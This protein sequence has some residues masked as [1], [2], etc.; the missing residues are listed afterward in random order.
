MLPRGVCLA[1]K[2]VYVTVIH[3]GI[4]T[5]TPT[6]R[7]CNC[8]PRVKISGRSC[9]SCIVCSCRFAWV[10]WHYLSPRVGLTRVQGDVVLLPVASQN[11]PSVEGPCARVSSIHPA[12]DGVIRPNDRLSLASPCSVTCDVPYNC[13]ARRDNGHGWYNVLQLLIANNLATF[14]RGAFSLAKLNA[15]L[16]RTCGNC[17]AAAW[18]TC[19]ST[20]G[21]RAGRTIRWL[22]PT[23]CQELVALS[24]RRAH[25]AAV[26]SPVRSQGARER[27]RALGGEW[28]RG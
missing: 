12:T 11:S 28:V 18:L 3:C 20:R 15:G 27:A 6:C 2:D 1:C 8:T 13:C 21:G 16:V 17:L 4:T 10:A 22:Q 9:K 14:Y 25:T 26:G 5:G 7:Q 24:A 23:H 19:C